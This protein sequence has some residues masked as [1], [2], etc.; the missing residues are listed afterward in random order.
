MPDD[1][2][3]RLR[4]ISCYVSPSPAKRNKIEDWYSK[5]TVKERS[6]ADVFI[7]TMRQKS[8]D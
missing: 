5:L 6:D 4:P 1:V 8:E 3:A 7:K 2:S